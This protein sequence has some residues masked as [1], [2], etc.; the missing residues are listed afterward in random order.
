MAGRKREARLS[1][2]DPAIHALLSGG[3]KDVD[4]RDKPGHDDKEKA[5]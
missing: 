5:I 3:T 1:P 4:A 2:V